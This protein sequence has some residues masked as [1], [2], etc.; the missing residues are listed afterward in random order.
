MMTRDERIEALLARGYFPKEL[1]PPFTSFDFARSLANIVPHWATH[2]AG[3]TGQQRRLYPPTSRYARFDMARKGHSRRMLGVPNPVNQYYLTSAIADHQDEFEA[4][5]ARSPISLTSTQISQTGNRAVTLPKL[6]LL[7]EERIKAYATARAILQTDVLSFYHAIYTHSIPWALHGKRVTKRNRSTTD[8]AVYGNR[9]DALLRACQDGQTI[10][11]PVGPDSSRIISELIL[12]AIEQQIGTDHFARLTAGYRYMDDFFL[13]FASHVDAE[14]F[15]AALREAVLGFDLQLNASKT[16]IIDALG[17]N[18]ESWPGDIAQLKLSRSANDQRRDLIRF[19]SEVI[20]LSKSWPDES[21][22][23][24]AVRK[25]SHSLIHSANW[26]V[27][28]PFLLRIARENSNCLDSVIKILCTYAAAGYP[29]GE[30]IKDFAEGM[31]EEHAPYNHHYEVVWTLWLCRSLSIRLGERATQLSAKV[32]N[33]LCACLV[34]MLRS[35]SLLTGRG[36]I[37]DWIGTVD[38]DDLMGEHWMLVYEAGIRKGWK[39]PGAEAAVD[40]DPHFR[41]LRDQRVSFFNTV[42][43]NVALELPTINQLL[44]TSLAGRRSAVLSGNIYAESRTPRHKRRYE[45]L[46]EDYGN[47]NSGWR[48]LWDDLSLDDDND[49]DF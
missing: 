4:I 8:P 2:E 45:K 32:E 48:P 7:S 30:R 11:I 27:Y 22:A 25:T 20:R 31:I 17:F 1:P 16:Q 38:A 40:A 19:F 47:D 13:C 42:A 23:S 28:E 41:V 5:S 44:D 21:I 18:E 26:D 43:T 9:I 33:S 24:F 14:A 12:C 34:F 6:S 49:F 3:L 35:R 36:A 15:L 39:L 37:S 29:I 10:G 46:G